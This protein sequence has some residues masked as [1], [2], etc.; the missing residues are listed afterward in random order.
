M[1]RNYEYRFII[2][3]RRTQGK[4][5]LVDLVECFLSFP[6]TLLE[7][8]HRNRKERKRSKLCKLAISQYIHVDI[9]K[10]GTIVSRARDIYVISISFDFRWTLPSN[11]FEENSIPFN[12]LYTYP[13][14][15][16]LTTLALTYFRWSD[17]EKKVLSQIKVE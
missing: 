1:H 11:S 16:I 3:E 17:L 14:T 6:S 9:C 4:V 2:I 5:D 8:L 7:P 15:C 12:C 13:H 10:A